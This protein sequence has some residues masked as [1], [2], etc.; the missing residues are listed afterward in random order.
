M[1]MSRLLNSCHDCG[2]MPGDTH[3][4]NCDTER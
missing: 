2:A 1:R 3:S 4:E